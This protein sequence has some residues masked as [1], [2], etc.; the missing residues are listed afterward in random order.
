MTAAVKHM[1]RKKPGTAAAAAPAQPRNSQL[2]ERFPART[3]QSWWPGTAE[4][5][6]ETQ[7]RLTAPP[8]L[9]EVK[10]TRAGRRRGWP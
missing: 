8:F 6:Q 9:P 10:A 2:R 4:D 7:R 3:A 1:A 5:E